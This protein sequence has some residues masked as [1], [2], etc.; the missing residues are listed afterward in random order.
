M[1][2]ITTEM[3]SEGIPVFVIPGA[4]TF[5]VEK[6]KAAKK[7]PIDELWPSKATAIP[8]NPI[9]K[10]ELWTKKFWKVPN[11]SAT[12]PRPASA[13]AMTIDVMIVRFAEIPAYSDALGFSPTARISKPSVVLENN[14]AMTIKAIMAMI[15]PIFI[16]E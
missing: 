5:S 4:P 8:S 9:C 12:P 16:R 15:I 14:M 1:V 11:P 6:R 7:I 3:I 2:A 13:P 10:F